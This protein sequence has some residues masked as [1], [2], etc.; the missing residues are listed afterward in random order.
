MSAG[1]SLNGLW[2]CTAQ[3][4]IA[5]VLKLQDDISFLMMKKAKAFH[6]GV[7][8]LFES[9]TVNGNTVELDM[10]VTKNRMTQSILVGGGEQPL[11]NLAGK[12]F[13]VTPTWEGE[14]LVLKVGDGSMQKRTVVDGYMVLEVEFRGVKAK[15][16]FTRVEDT[17]LTGKMEAVNLETKQQQDTIESDQ[18]N[19]PDTAKKGAKQTGLTGL[20]K[21]SGQENMQDMLVVSGANA[22]LKKLAAAHKFGVG[23]VYENIKIEGDTVEILG[24]GL[25]KVQM[26]C[27]VGAGEQKLV[28]L[29][30]TERLAT[31]TWAGKDGAKDVLVVTSGEIIATRYLLDEDTM[32]LELE[33]S[34]KKA[35]RIFS[36]RS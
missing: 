33:H 26:R 14:A 31:P 16:I 32:V 19:T 9:I 11:L 12:T 1:E 18:A 29:S 28:D 3:E 13:T 23:L 27:I 21:C 17:T 10:K 4:N 2:K 36:R 25:K 5:E 7:N 35:K 6:Y 15:R 20:W 30:G 22:F 34:G 24:K 8:L